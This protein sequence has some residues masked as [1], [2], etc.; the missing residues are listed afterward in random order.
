VARDDP[1]ALSLATASLFDSH[2]HLADAQFADDLPLVLERARAAGIREVLVPAAEP[3]DAD[4]A[5]AIASLTFGPVHAPG[6][7]GAERGVAG[8]PDAGS[9]DAARALPRIYWSA[10]LHPHEARRWGAGTAGEIVEKLEAGAAAVGETGL[11]FHYDH[12]P[13]DAQRAAFETQAALA[14]ER[15]LP[16]IVHS[17]E[18]DVET[19]AIL[20][21]SGIAAERVILHCFS[22][23]PALFREALERGYYVSFSGLITFKRYDTPH[24]LS[25]VAAERLLI[26]TDAPYLAPVPLRGRR[27][28]PAFLPATLGRLAA[29]RGLD[30]AEAARLTRAN[31]L[32]VYKL[33]HPS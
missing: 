12:S 1:P 27:N 23:G 13:R 31:A 17:R 8:E 7:P 10:G 11:D 25:E 22:A 4:R 18:A 14:R 19:V 9:R 3:A 5:A 6:S 24:Y 29:A 28:E 20:R 32:R 21:G 16:L 33:A 26:E 30:P 2:A 15:D